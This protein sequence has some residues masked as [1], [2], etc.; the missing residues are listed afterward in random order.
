MASVAL[1]VPVYK[2]F[3]GF[4]QLIHSVDYPIT[5]VIGPNWEEN[6]GCSR[7][8]NYGIEYASIHDI[9][10]AL[11]CN[12]DVFFDAGTIAKLVETLEDHP[13]FDLVSAVNRRDAPP[14][15][16][17]RYPET[18]DFSCFMVRNDFLNRF[19]DF[20]E[21]FFPAYFEDNDMAYRIKIA[22]GTY[23]CRTDASM[24]H[25][26]SVTQN[27]NPFDPVVDSP[28][29]EKNRAYYVKKWGGTPGNERYTVPFGGK[30]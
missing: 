10:Y 29:F 18:P 3:P 21:N 1:V 8:W 6:L 14:T 7:T 4:A 22:G 15:E 17:I 24:Y 23:V 13:E 2:N 19:G 27:W 12:D 20:D 16:D 26:G 25:H 11:V 30:E 28:N 9:D 5:P